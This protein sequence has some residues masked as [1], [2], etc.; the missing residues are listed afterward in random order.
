MKTFLSLSFLLFAASSFASDWSF[1]YLDKLYRK[2]QER[3][4]DRC[5]T[6]MN[7]FPNEESPYFFA[8]KIQLEDAKQQ[9]KVKSKNSRM[10]KAI[11]YAN[12]FDKNASTE[13]KQHIQWD[14]VQA[15]LFDR[16]SEIRVELDD[17][18]LNSNIKQLDTKWNKYAG[19]S[20]K[21]KKSVEVTKTEVKPVET[22]IEGVEAETKE[23]ATTNGNIAF[24]GMPKG[25]ENVPVF[26]TK[27]EKELLI[28]INKE[29]KRLKMDTLVWNADLSRAARYHATDMG[30]QDYFDHNSYDRKNGKLVEVGDT[31][32]RIRS[33]YSSTF[34]N[35]ENIAAGNSTAEGTYQQWFNSPGHY[36]NMFNKSSKY[37]G[38]GMAKVDGG[39]GYY[40][41]FCTAE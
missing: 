40:W 1:N 20:L 38:I 22:E 15:Y 17:G 37:V 35:S 30:T 11:D 36:A 5:R 13:L 21:P 4:Y 25:T 14:T 12:Y 31:F 29:R 8:M 41:V 34:V 32:D 19:S 33:F 26:D 9:T 7:L 18:N 16:A 23:V 39:Y 28:M 3:C 27:S 24:F 6:L 2:N 10:I